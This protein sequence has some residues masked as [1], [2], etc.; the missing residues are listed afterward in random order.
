MALRALAA[1]GRG[2]LLVSQD[3]ALLASVAQRVLV[4]ADGAVAAEGDPRELLARRQPM[5]DP[6]LGALEPGGAGGPAR[7][8]GAGGAPALEIRG[9]SA[10]YGARNVLDGVT[11]AVPRGITSAWMGE[12]GAGK[13]TLAR[14][15]MGLVPAR[16][17]T[18]SVSGM[19][20]DALPVEG[21]ARHVGLVFQNPAAQLFGRTV[22]EEALF[23]HGCWGSRART[24]W[25]PRTRR[26]RPWA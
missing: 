16:A 3:L 12:N 26:S 21:R 22:L 1:A 14:A 15:V 4:L 5:L 8:T 2:V 10:G 25:P 20:L 17:G 23:G 6:R 13:S 19:P 9:L 11:L 24:R 18:I 7:Q